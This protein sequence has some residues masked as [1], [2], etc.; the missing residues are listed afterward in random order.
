MHST[1][2]NT[3]K[4]TKYSCL[5]LLANPIVLCENYASGKL[6][7]VIPQNNFHHHA[8]LNLKPL[9]LP[10]N[11]P[12]YL[13]QILKVLGIKNQNIYNELLPDPSLLLLA[14]HIAFQLF[15]TSFNI[16]LLE[17]RFLYFCHKFSL[18]YS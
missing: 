18:T 15:R 4:A 6:L 12:V 10:L 9:Q 7:I 13:L 11:P 8:Q 1:L 2:N 3:Q 16:I 5:N 14:F 17:K